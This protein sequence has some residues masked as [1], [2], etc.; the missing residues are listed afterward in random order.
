MFPNV[1]E[2]TKDYPLQSKVFGHRL[3]N[4]QTIYEYILEFLQVM[5][6]PKALKELGTDYEDY[7]PVDEDI[8]NNIIEFYPVSRVG[9]KRFIFFNKSKEEGRFK[10]DGKA[11]EECVG[12][13]EEMISI[14]SSY[15]FIDKQYA[16]TMLQNLLYGFNAVIKNRS[17][18]AQNLLPICPE[19]I[20]PEAMGD[21][22]K[23]KDIS[24]ELVDEVFEFNRYNFMARGG[25]VYY[26]HLLKTINDYPEY[27]DSI[28]NG[29]RDLICSFPQF[30]KLCDFINVTWQTKCEKTPKKVTKTLGCIPDGFD[31]REKYTAKELTNFLSSGI[32]PFEKIDI[33]SYGMLL[34]M[35]KM[36]HEQACF[37]NNKQVPFWVVDMRFQG[38]TSVEVKKLAVKNYARYEED[39]L[40]ALYRHL[41]GNIKTGKDELSTITDAAKDTYKLYRKL[42]KEIGIIIP[43]TGVGMRFTLSERIVKFLTLSLIPPKGKLTL[44]TFLDKIYDHYRIVVSRKHYKIEMDRNNA[45]YLNDLSFLDKNKEAFQ[46]MLKDCGLLRDISD[47]TSIVENPYN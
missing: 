33:L 19:V 26:L 12:A 13:L 34:Q 31:R 39:I 46:Q 7:F 18:F 40:K 11:Y 29:F 45:E 3:R 15:D 23:R 43:I 36:L 9:L 32:H 35:L 28:E 24:F 16:I 5:I 8:K 10:V 42:G 44:D 47:S 6:A 4:D 37:A 30:S 17:W 41:D 14:E 21:K 2:L 1:E 38:E 22:K 20:L 25:E 27:K